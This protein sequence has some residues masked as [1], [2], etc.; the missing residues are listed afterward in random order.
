MVTREVIDRDTGQVITPADY[1]QLGWLL[2]TVALIG[3]VAPL[4][5][6]ALV[7]MSRFRTTD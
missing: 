6:I 2:I 3:L 4:A 7:Q 1:S 5:T